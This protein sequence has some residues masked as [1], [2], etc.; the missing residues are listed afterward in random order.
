M[1]QG[2]EGAWR[3][4]VMVVDQT[5]EVLVWR[6]HS[7]ETSHHVHSQP[8]ASLLFWFTSPNLDHQIKRRRV[9]VT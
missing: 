7:R 5:F 6:S 3:K 9:A 8:R 2:V 1:V 4:Y